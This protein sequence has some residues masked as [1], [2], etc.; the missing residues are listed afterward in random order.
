[1][2]LAVLGWKAA[3]L[4]LVPEI[5]TPDELFL[6]DRSRVVGLLIDIDRLLAFRTRRARLLG[7]AT[8]GPYTNPAR[9]EEEMKAA[10]QIF[11]RGRFHV[12]DVTDKPVEASADEIIRWIGERQAPQQV[13]D[14]AST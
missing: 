11:R 2:Y 12:I 8:N 9:I 10:R 3:N 14:T 4:P 7:M 6:L 1:M 13:T 5:P